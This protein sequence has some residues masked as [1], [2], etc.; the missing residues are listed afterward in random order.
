MQETSGTARYLWFVVTTKGFIG[1]VIRLCMLM[2]R[3]DFSGKKMQKAICEIEDVGKRYGYEPAILIPAIVLQRHSTFLGSLQHRS[4]EIGIHGYRHILF[5]PLSLEQQVSQIQKAKDVFR[6]CKV[7]A[8]GFR[9]PYLSYSSQTIKAVQENDLLWQSNESFIWNNSASSVLPRLR[10]FTANAIRL[11]YKPLEAQGNVIIPRLCGRVVCIPIT[12]P[13]DEILVD[14]IGVRDPEEIEQIWSEI[15]E[16]NHQRGG[17]FV[18]QLHP[19]RFPF[20]RQALL[21]LLERASSSNQPVWISSMNDIAMWWREKQ[22][23][24]FTFQKSSPDGYSVHCMCTDRATVICRNCHRERSRPR[25]YQDYH[26]VEGTDFFVESGNLKPCIGVHT[27]CS[28]A[29]LGFLEDEGFYYE[30]TDNIG[31]YSLFLDDYATFSMEDEKALL[32]RIEES[33]NPIVRY[34]RWPNQTRSALATTHDLDCF[35][36][37]DFFLRAIGR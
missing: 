17:I 8:T 18:L 5:E 19:E 13:D 24:K 35:T 26:I 12:L 30:I 16:M 37:P 4:L 33:H 34:W 1:A 20:C 23:F 36:L 28:K 14:R 22:Q 2:A 29:L 31:E 27:R 15:F 21:S 9:S 3:F 32:D 11:L 25:F 6:E 10:Q 7:F